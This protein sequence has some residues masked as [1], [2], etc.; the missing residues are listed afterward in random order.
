MNFRRPLL[1]IVLSVIALSPAAAVAVESQRTRNVC[2]R[3]NTPHGIGQAICV[4]GSLY[5]CTDEHPAYNPIWVN[6]GGC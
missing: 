6:V 5:R 4:G 3:F 1:L 2:Y